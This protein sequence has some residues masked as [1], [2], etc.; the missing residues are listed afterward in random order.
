MAALQT[1]DPVAPGTVAPSAVVWINGQEAIV[2]AMDHEGRLSTCE[3]YRGTS[4]ELGYLAQVVRIIG[5]RERVV[6]L[7]PSSARLA[8]ERE[9]VAIYKRPD[10]L[11]DVEPSER[12]TI[13]DLVARVRTLAE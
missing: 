4:P 11:V 2:V 1:V 9:Y 10:R 3:V 13:D 7:G 8:L 12:V 6:I 5:D